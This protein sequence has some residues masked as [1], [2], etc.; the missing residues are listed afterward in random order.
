M[1][2]R[3]LVLCIESSVMPELFRD[4]SND[5]FIL[6]FFLFSIYENYLFYGYHYTLGVFLLFFFH[7]Y[8]KC[9]GSCNYAKEFEILSKNDKNM[10]IHEN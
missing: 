5:I 2:F 1:C 9:S 10:C 4:K 8:G 3:L 6:V 7:I